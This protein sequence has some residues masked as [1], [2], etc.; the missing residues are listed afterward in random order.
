M[1]NITFQLNL[2]KKSHVFAFVASQICIK[3]PFMY[4]L[5]SSKLPPF[6]SLNLQ[7]LKIK[8]CITFHTIYINEHIFIAML[9]RL[10]KVL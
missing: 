1:I 10:S 6:Y 8:S 7:K 9:I 4:L 3:K 2:P 5:I